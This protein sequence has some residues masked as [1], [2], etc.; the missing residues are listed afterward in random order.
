[1]STGQKLGLVLAAV[2]VGAVAGVIV[3]QQNGED[4]A[5][6]GISEGLDPG[7]GF[8]RTIR[9]VT[10]ITPRTHLFGDAVVA[11]AD[12]V[13][14]PRRVDPDTVRIDA[15]FDPYQQVGSP[16]R[17]RSN[18]DDLVRLRFQYTLRCMTAGC[19]PVAA[20]KQ[21][22]MPIGQMVYRL[23]GERIVDSFDWPPIGTASRITP[24]DLEEARW[25]ADLR[26]LPEVSYRV[27]P[28]VLGAVLAGAAVLLALAAGG[29][30][31]FLL[32]ARARHV[33]EEEVPTISPLERA[34]AAVGE[35]SANGATPEQR[36]A[37]ER[38]AREL[39]R[40]G[41][42]ELATRTERPRSEDLSQLRGD[43]EDELGRGA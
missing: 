40:A 15:D 10:S 12:L 36:K 7:F 31:L 13:L 2:V 37:L 23:A 33:A 14:D 28:G 32:P 4:E 22:T 29:L 34:L 8:E 17:L 11:E 1:V 24:I 43:V 19:A 16:R 6:P 30:A 26:R 21:T 25:R 35:L 27:A 5:G 18:G 42:S 9:L 20:R 3:L 38:L 39:G 41:L